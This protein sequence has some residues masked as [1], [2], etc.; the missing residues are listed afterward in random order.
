MGSNDRLSIKRCRESR[1][2]E[3]NAYYSTVLL[4]VGLKDAFG[5][6]EPCSFK[7]SEPTM[8]TTKSK[9]VHP[10]V[11]FQCDNDTK[12]I[13]CEIKSSLPQKRQ[14]LLQDL[15]EQIDKYAEIESGWITNSG[16]IR[17]H[18]TLLLVRRGDIR[19]VHDLVHRNGGDASI[20]VENFCL[21]YWEEVKTKDHG[22]GDVMRLGREE[23]S[24]GCKY[25]DKRLDDNIEI[26]VENT[27]TGYEKRK[28]VKACPPHLY[29]L[30]VLYQD[31]L[32]DFLND[33]GHIIVSIEDLRDRLTEFYASWSS[34]PG[35][36]SQI[37]PRWIKHALDTLHDIQLATKL[38]NGQYRISPPPRKKNV[39]DFL[40]DKMC[41]DGKQA[42]QTRIND[43]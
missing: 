3:Y 14:L 43:Y 12:G 5:D 29:M 6:D 27:L 42:T 38:P 20:H 19:R 11:I 16:K 13:V 33:D 17:R 36:Q 37:R 10:D 22:V 15:K 18:S 4:A 41:G 40:L 9:E 35:K 31:I 26:P 25:F 8:Y 39:M 32:P 21:A 28:F 7:V 23:G 1:S 34:L 30:T 24:T 2:A